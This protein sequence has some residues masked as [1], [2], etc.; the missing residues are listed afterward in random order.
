MNKYICALCGIIIAIFGIIPVSAYSQQDIYEAADKAFDWILSEASPLKHPDSAASDN[1]VT[2]LSR[3]GRSFD[4][5]K[6]LS[7]TESRN[8]STDMDGQRLIMTE[9]A[10]G[11]RTS[12]SFVRLYTY[13]RMREDA[14]DLAGAIITLDSGGYSIKSSEISM[15]HMVLTLMTMQQ[16]DG[17]FGGDIYTTARA[18]IALSFHRGS[19]YDI[20]GTGENESYSYSTETAIANA[21]SYLASR[22]GSDGGFGT[23]TNT[24]YSAMALDSVGINYEKDGRFAP[25]GRTPLDWI[26]T[27]QSSDGSFNSSPD[28]TALAACALVSHLRAIQ[29]KAGFFRFNSA[30]SVASSSSG[31]ESSVSS[32]SAGSQG[33][34]ASNT[35]THEAAPTKTDPPVIKLTPLPTRAPQH[36]ELDEEEYGPIPPMGPLKPSETGKP[37]PRKSTEEIAKD[38]SNAS[39]AVSATV[40]L[41]I[42]IIGAV[43]FMYLRYPEKLRSFIELIRKKISGEAPSG[44]EQAKEVSRAAENDMLNDT[45]S[46]APAVSTEE[47]YDPDFLKKLIPVD[48]LDD[49]IDPIVPKTDAD[50]EK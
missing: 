24:A 47:L 6:Y 28:D 15:D 30:D 34:A 43:I 37:E 31:N 11:S 33:S 26:I 7:Y 4:F 2:A 46:S 23:F 25:G 39:T 36:S 49:K 14:T 44:S 45:E 20:S 1:S 5:N 35:E 40:I 42:I 50:D 48:E 29:G 13:N 18:M 17:S 38:R 32:G 16:A 21:A 41:L 8:P 27:K 10:C 19:R 9:T 22:I 12:D 3:M